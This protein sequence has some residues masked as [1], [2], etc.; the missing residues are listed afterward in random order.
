MLRDGQIHN[1][2]NGEMARPVDAAAR[3]LRPFFE[4]SGDGAE[5]WNPRFEGRYG[6]VDRI[7]AAPGAEN[8]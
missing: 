3:R 6:C 8:L 5:A 2:S 1:V 7:L 4:E